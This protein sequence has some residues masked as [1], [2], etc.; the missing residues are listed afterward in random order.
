VDWLKL[1][2]PIATIIATII[3]IIWA[4]IVWRK[5]KNKELKN[6]IDKLSALYI[7]PFML[8]CEELQSRFYNILELDGLN[9]LKDRQPDGG[10]AEET[11]YL[12]LQYFGWANCIYRYGPY[13]QNYNVIEKIKNI[14]NLFGTGKYGEEH[15]YFPRHHQ[16]ALGKSITKRVSGEFI[17][18]FDL[19]SLYEFGEKLTNHVFKENKYVNNSIKG[20]KNAADRPEGIDQKERERL[21]KIQNNLVDLLAYLERDVGFSLYAGKRGKAQ[22]LKNVLPK[23]RVT[24]NEK[25]PPAQTLLK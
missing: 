19:I 24:L 23:V 13:A 12:I 7:N 16:T 25:N 9:T 14:K 8:A 3:T 21:V 2:Q 15:F 4:V 1:S 11:V 22:L 5:Q 20:F 10:Y 6:K 18:E 17:Y